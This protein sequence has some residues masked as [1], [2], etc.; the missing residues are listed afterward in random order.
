MSLKPHFLHS[1]LVFPENMGAVSD[2]H[3]ERY[4]HDIS[5]IEKRYSRK[6]SPNMFADCCWS[7]IME[8]PT[9]KYERPTKTK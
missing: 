6:W 2:E 3:G 9:S 1:H 4:N 7:L 5:Q 8:T